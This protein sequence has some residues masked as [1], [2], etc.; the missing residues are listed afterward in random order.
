VR[1][2]VTALGAVLALTLVACNHDTTLKET[3][4]QIA[5]EQA[6]ADAHNQDTVPS[7]ADDDTPSTDVVTTT[8][9]P[10]PEYEGT[11]QLRV[12]DCVDLPTMRTASVRPIACDRPHHSEVTARG[13]LRARFP[14]GAPTDDD[15]G[16]SAGTDCE[17]AFDAYVRK[18]TPPGVENGSL[19]PL[20][21]SW[22]MGVRD[23]IC[24]AQADREG[25][26]L[27]GSVRKGA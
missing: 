7:P 20:P 12:G 3:P 15:Y 27:T 21:E 18:P 26:V 16:H 24:L 19:D 9:T 6:A 25:N 4:Q 5:Q 23:V 2:L 11:D 13:D 17:Q 22:F 14:N 1:L 8:T 10:I